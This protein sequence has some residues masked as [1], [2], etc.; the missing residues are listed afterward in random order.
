MDTEDEDTSAIANAG[1]LGNDGGHYLGSKCHGCFHHV[2]NLSIRSPTAWRPT[3]PL[4]CWQ[5]DTYHCT[6]LCPWIPKAFPTL[7]R[8]IHEC[9]KPGGLGMTAPILAVFN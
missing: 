7:G 4:C 3:E 8:I 9:S 6:H 2:F 5:Y 1:E